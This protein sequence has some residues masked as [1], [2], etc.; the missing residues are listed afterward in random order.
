MSLSTENQAVALPHKR[1][2]RASF[3]IGVTCIIIILL[4]VGIV[5][6]WSDVPEPMMTVLQLLPAGLLC[7]ALIGI[8]LGILG[9]ADRSSRKLYPLLGLALNVIVL[10]VF[11]A[12][13]ILGML[14]N[15]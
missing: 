3:I 13:A 15:A 14:L 1:R 9:A 7:A 12:V 2:G 10:M 11:F 5:M 8:V 6:I 4:M